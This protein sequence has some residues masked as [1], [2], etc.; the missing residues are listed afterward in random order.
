[1]ENDHDFIKSHREAV[2]PSNAK[3]VAQDNLKNSKQNFS[4]HF[5]PHPSLFFDPASPLFQSPNI[6]TNANNSTS[7][8]L[9]NN[10]EQL[11]FSFIRS[12]NSPEENP[13]LK[14]HIYSNFSSISP[15]NSDSSSIFKYKS[16]LN[17]AE[18]LS[19]D[20][21]DF[22]SEIFLSKKNIRKNEFNSLLNRFSLKKQFKHEKVL[23]SSDVFKTKSL[24]LSKKN[25][26]PSDLTRYHKD[27]V[28]ITGNNSSPASGSKFFS[29]KA[30]I[31][32]IK[33]SKSISPKNSEKY[34]QNSIQLF[35][36]DS[37]SFTQ[38]SSKISQRGSVRFSKSL[39]PINGNQFSSKLKVVSTSAPDSLEEVRAQDVGSIYRFKKEHDAKFSSPNNKPQSLEIKNIIINRR[40][41]RDIKKISDLSDIEEIEENSASPEDMNINT[42][43]SNRGKK[44]TSQSL[45]VTFQHTRKIKKISKGFSEFLISIEMSEVKDK[46]C[47]NVRYRKRILRFRFK[48]KAVSRP[49]LVYYPLHLVKNIKFLFKSQGIFINSATGRYI[50]R[51][52]LHHSKYKISSKISGIKNPITV[53]KDILIDLVNMEDPLSFVVISPSSFT[54]EKFKLIGFRRE[55]NANINLFPDTRGLNTERNLPISYSLASRRRIVEAI[56][57]VNRFIDNP[58][59]FNDNLNPNIFGFKIDSENAAM[60]FFGYTIFIVLVISFLVMIAFLVSSSTCNSNYLY[61]SDYISKNRYFSSL[62]YVSKFTPNDG[63]TL[64]K[65]LQPYSGTDVSEFFIPYSEYMDP[66]DDEATKY[67]SFMSNCNYNSSLARSWYGSY[68]ADLDN[69]Y[70]LEFFNNANEDNKD[71]VSLFNRNRIGMSYFSLSP[72]YKEESYPNHYVIIDKSIYDF[73]TYLKYSVTFSTIDGVNTLNINQTTN[74]ISPEILE[75]ILYNKGEDISA[76]LKALNLAD[77]YPYAACFDP[78]FLRGVTNRSATSYA[79]VGVGVFEWLLLSPMLLGFLF[80]TLIY[81]QILF[82]IKISNP[83]KNSMSLNIDN[84]A[85][86][87]NTNH[88]GKFNEANSPGSSSL[89]NDIGDVKKDTDDPIRLYT[90]SNNNF[91]NENM[92]PLSKDASDFTILPSEEYQ[93]HMENGTGHSKVIVALMANKESTETIYSTIYSILNSSYPVENLVLFAVIDGDE[94]VLRRFL[95]E[96]HYR[97]DEPD[98][99]IYG[100]QGQ[101]LHFL[102]QNENRGNSGDSIE[103]FADFLFARVFKGVY[104]KNGR[105]ISYIV[106]A[107][108]SYQGHLD[109]IMLTL[110]LFR[111]TE[112]IQSISSAITFEPVP[113]GQNLYRKAEGSSSDDSKEYTKGKDTDIERPERNAIFLED[114]LHNSFLAINYPINTFEYF[115]LVEAGASIE[116]YSIESMLQDM[117]GYQ[118]QRYY[119]HL[120]LT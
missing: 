59:N 103:G 106:V 8:S 11:F 51:N 30:C 41:L 46:K 53:K 44:R 47:L 12:R 29:Q 92:Y 102:N 18:I 25:K 99:K 80:Q 60:N 110:G 15:I 75:I 33:N 66:K 50:V 86:F 90:Q 67:V 71:Y 24:S 108:D 7:N 91:L 119:K 42:R 112:S 68:G 69:F 79:C 77:S 52:V 96:L 39:L 111:G 88:Q 31:N 54:K 100:S 118:F 40:R 16:L 87:Q 49:K 113:G 62:G 1:M 61:S 98:P 109:S 70:N 36:K 94:D 9:L 76:K 82:R 64:Y 117:K 65:L 116:K 120:N 37:Q 56:R 26:P 43:L 3:N 63:S 38:N 58:L 78:F 4:H 6:P 13:Q 93:G 104:E 32:Y 55:I 23:K 20:P 45:E 10:E 5:Y 35:E 17:D 2:P 34:L 89:R 73:S 114:E 14:K 107:K 21:F 85:G 83:S 27:P 101:D 81:F 74:F 105:S 115:L 48:K 22:N 84:R 19:I 97:G 95:V 57:V 72:L 28:L